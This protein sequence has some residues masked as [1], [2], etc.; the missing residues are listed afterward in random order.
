[1]INILKRIAMVLTSASLIM[2]TA[3][4]NAFAQENEDTFVFEYIGDNNMEGEGSIGNDPFRNDENMDNWTS[5]I[6]S[7]HTNIFT[8]VDQNTQDETQVY[9]ADV[10]TPAI[11]EEAASWLFGSAMKYERVNIEDADYY[12]QEEAEKVRAILNNGYWREETKVTTE[13]GKVVNKVV[14]ESDNDQNL[15]ELVNKVSS[16]TDVDLSGLTSKE[17][18][19]ATQWAI[20]TMTNNHDLEM[21]ERYYSDYIDTVLVGSHYEYIIDENGQPQITNVDGAKSRARIFAVRDYLLG[22]DGIKAGS[23]DDTAS[24]IFSDQNFV[25]TNEEEVNK[26]KEDAILAGSLITEADADG[27]IE[28]D[29][30]D[31]YIKSENEDVYVITKNEDDTYTVEVFYNVLG[32]VGENDELQLFVEMT[33]EEGNVV[34]T[35]STNISSNGN[36]L[37][38]GIAWNYNA[39][40]KTAKL[41]VNMKNVIYNLAMNVTGVQETEA[42][43]YLY[44]SEKRSSEI[45]DEEEMT[46][47][48]FV[49]WGQGETKV[50]A[51]R[52]FTLDLSNMTEA[53]VVEEDPIETFNP[54][55]PTTPEETEDPVT[56]SSLEETVTPEQPKTPNLLSKPKVEM[57]KKEMNTTESGAPNTGIETQTSTYIALLMISAL[58]ARIVAGFWLTKK[59]K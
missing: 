7:T 20:W 37:N 40:N 36:S 35:L 27:K 21:L 49:G 58:M 17:A 6:Q 43:Y 3:S 39:E 45:F 41:V 30:G 44:R 34:D 23:N 19:T 8:V 26:A 55:E 15:T 2:G 22:L 12:S 52:T 10:T 47:Q 9:C 5:Y 31:V 28:M 16:Q 50:F 56:P 18:I 42:G 24:K 25:N 38:N 11:D 14:S 4:I 46:S 1:M 59:E 53:V 13:D 29:T 54:E 32:N 57:V 48:T 51:S 33:D